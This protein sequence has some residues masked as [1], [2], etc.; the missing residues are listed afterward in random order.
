MKKAFTILGIIFCLC[1]VF[2]MVSC[3]SDKIYK[4]KSKTTCETLNLETEA[5]KYLFMEQ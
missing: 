1:I 5:I 3:N 4:Y 2:I